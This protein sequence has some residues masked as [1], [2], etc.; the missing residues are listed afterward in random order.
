MPKA[1]WWLEGGFDSRL[2]YCYLIVGNI[3]GLSRVGKQILM[4]V[5]IGVIYVKTSDCFN[6][7]KA[8]QMGGD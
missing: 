6:T 8:P 2:S 7:G 4:L 5:S 3:C 1:A